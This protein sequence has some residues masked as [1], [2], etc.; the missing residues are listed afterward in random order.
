MTSNDDH[1][2][3]PGDRPG[4]IT[5]PNVQ[6][7]Y[8]DGHAIIEHTCLNR[9]HQPER[10]RAVLPNGPWQI[11]DTDPLTVTPSVHC[12][13]CG[14]HGWITAGAFWTTGGPR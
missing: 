10:I 13:W 1:G 3:R 14:L 5:A 2:I 8:E 6:L 9:D 12:R 7:S 11:K 4:L